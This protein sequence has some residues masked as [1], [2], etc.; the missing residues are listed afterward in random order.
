MI[1]DYYEAIVMNTLAQ[2]SAIVLPTTLY[3][4]L[5][6]TPIRKQDDIGSGPTEI[7]GSGYARTALSFGA[8]AKGLTV[9]DAYCPLFIPSAVLGPVVATALCDASTAGHIVF[10]ALCKPFILSPT[11]LPAGI[12]SGRL[13][14][15][16]K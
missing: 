16:L 12:A 5:F 6:S 15:S 8:W 13:R 2:G 1:S 7:T 9:L 3:L 4:G 11:R 10:S 14:V